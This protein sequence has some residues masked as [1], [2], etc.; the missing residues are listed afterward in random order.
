MRR[1]GRRDLGAL[2]FG[3]VGFLAIGSEVA[4]CSNANG[5]AYAKLLQAPRS[6]RLTLSP[7]TGTRPAVQNF[8]ESRQFSFLPLAAVLCAASIG[9]GLRKGGPST[10]SRVRVQ[11]L[12]AAPYS[13]SVD[14]PSIGRESAKPAACTQSTRLIDLGSDSMSSLTTAA[15]P[16]VAVPTVVSS[17]SNMASTTSSTDSSVTAS[18]R[19]K[20]QSSPRGAKNQQG[21]Q[22]QERRHFGAKLLLGSSAKPEVFTPSFDPSKVRQQIQTGLRMAS[23]THPRAVRDSSKRSE[24][25]APLSNE[26]G[27]TSL[28][29]ITPN[30]HSNLRR[31]TSS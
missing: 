25:L 26:W 10:K 19:G 7:V 8:Q 22:R 27:T 29:V 20:S 21:G 28:A 13:Y 6:G 2:I 24:K 16:C 14:A 11:V 9:M 3:F 17:W 1:L 18:S 23:C 30:S 4:F 5:A 15:G 31:R 12:A